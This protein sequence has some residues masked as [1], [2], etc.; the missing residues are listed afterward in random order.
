[1][2]ERVS[3]LYLDSKEVLDYILGL[4]GVSN[5]ILGLKGVPDHILGTFSGLERGPRL[6]YG[7][8]KAFQTIF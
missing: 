8:Q 2:L 7:P 3:R 4:E 1:M 6:Y 5:H